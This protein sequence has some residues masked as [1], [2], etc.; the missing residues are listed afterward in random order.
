MF[1]EP[2]IIPVQQEEEANPVE[3]SS[4]DVNNE[5]V[6]EMDF[7][8]DVIV[9]E[10]A[11]RRLSEDGH[12]DLSDY[13]TLEVVGGSDDAAEEWALSIKP[14]LSHFD[15]KKIEI[16]LQFRRPLD[17][18]VGSEPDY[19]VFTLTDNSLF[20]DAESGKPIDFFEKKMYLPK[21]VDTNNP[22]DV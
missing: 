22:E 6:L 5:G 12:L 7:S 4:A 2:E 1:L 11:R 9:P 15:S 16:S 19:A 17:V 20:T 8:K 14:V 10:E 21:L 13:S 18:S 3:V